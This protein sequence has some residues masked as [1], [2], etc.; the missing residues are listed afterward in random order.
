MDP[1]ALVGSELRWNAQA[2]CYLL[3]IDGARRLVW[4]CRHKSTDRQ[5]YVY[6]TVQ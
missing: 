4:P 6:H 2:S 3:S 5:A 1:V